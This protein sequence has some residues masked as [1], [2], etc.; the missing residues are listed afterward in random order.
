MNK[1]SDE[2]LY[3]TISRLPEPQ[4]I[5]KWIVLGG[6]C[7]AAKH[8]IHV[9]WAYVGLLWENVCDHFSITKDKV[10]I[11]VIWLFNDLGHGV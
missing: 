6:E 7:V 10:T 8:G 4:I 9:P 1:N 11:H 5:I 2:E 3:M